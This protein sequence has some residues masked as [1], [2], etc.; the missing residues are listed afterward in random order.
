MTEVDVE[1]IKLLSSIPVAIVTAWVT[2][3]LALRRF[4]SERWWERKVDSYTSLFVLITM[5]NL[6]GNYRNQH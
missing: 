6:P 2:V 1:L 3:W 5:Q 4:R